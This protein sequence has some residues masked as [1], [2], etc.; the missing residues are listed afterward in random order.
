M[1][2]PKMN[3]TVVLKDTEEPL[4]VQAI[5]PDLIRFETEQQ[6]RGL[7]SSEDA[8]LTWMTFLAWAALT[9]EGRYTKDWQE[10][11]LTDCLQLDMPDADETVDPT[12]QRADSDSA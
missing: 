11:K 5:N 6:K 1:S 8:P 9:R 2:L 3:L 12:Q 4:E 7:R 10:F